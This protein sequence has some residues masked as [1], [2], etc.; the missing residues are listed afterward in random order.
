MKKI[1]LFG[2]FITLSLLSCTDN[3]MVK[4]YGGS[5]ILNLSPNEKLINVTWKSDQLWLLTRPM[6]PTDTIE[7]YSFKEK[8]SFGVMEGEYIINESK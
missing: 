6:K 2:L 5:A 8:S 1:I 4:S 3:A 7:T